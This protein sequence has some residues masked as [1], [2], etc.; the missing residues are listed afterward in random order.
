MIDGNPIRA[1]TIVTKEQRYEIIYSCFDVAAIY[2]TTKH[3]VPAGTL[4]LVQGKRVVVKKCERKG[5]FS[6]DLR[7]EPTKVT[8]QDL[9]HR[10]RDAAL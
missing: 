2:I 5:L 1:K 8:L 10:I 6:Y 3:P 4:M 7:I 9:E